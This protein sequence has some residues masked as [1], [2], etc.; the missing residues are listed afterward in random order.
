VRRSGDDDIG[1]IT[2]SI[3]AHI[4]SDRTRENDAAD[5]K[6]NQLY[7][8]VVDTLASLA[9]SP[10]RPAREAAGDD[11]EIMLDVNCPRSVREAL[12]MTSM[13]RPFNLRW[14]EEPVWPLE[15]YSGLARVRQAAGIPIAAGEK[16]VDVDGF[17]APD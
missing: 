2:F 17:P 14:L 16:R 4:R 8:G 10:Q 15:N 13:L 7:D 1:D 3:V 6:A 5:G 11:I 12:D 9:R